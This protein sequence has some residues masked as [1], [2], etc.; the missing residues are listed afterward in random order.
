MQKKSEKFKIV[1]KDYNNEL[2][3]VLEKKYFTENAKSILLSILYKLEMSYKD[4]KQVK[5]DVEAKEKM[6]ENVINNVKDNCNEIK[7]VKPNSED[8]KILKGKNFLVDKNRK[9]IFC[10][11]IERKLLYAISKISKKDKIIKEKYF[12]IDETLSDLI[13]IGNNINTVEPLRDFNGYSWTTIPREIESIEYNLLYQNLIIL[14]GN[15]FL[16]KWINNKEVMI[17]YMEKFI[18]LMVK[19]YGKRAANKFINNLENISILLEM[20]YDKDKKRKI[21]KAKYEIEEK[22]DE[23]GNNR[24]YIARIT[25]EKRKLEHEIKYIDE[26]INDKNKLQK[27]YNARNENLP[28]EKKIFSMRILSKMMQEERA[29]KMAKIENLNKLLNPQKFMEY[30]NDLI[31]KIKLLEFVETRDLEKDIYRLKLDIQKAFLECFKHKVKNINAKQDMLRLIYQFRYYTLIPFN[32][33]II[34]KIDTV[35]NNISIDT[36]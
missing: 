15:E 30:K 28:L 14:I 6:I 16:D 21:V 36:S 8:S 27:E 1:K 12:L 17:D 35:I 3:E 25:K 24:T 2:E 32:Y 29:E 20:K 18:D 23:I 13:N 26:T 9:I 4:Y 22:L 31:K 19:T 10:Y 11:P 5:Q 33:E 7:L 34:N